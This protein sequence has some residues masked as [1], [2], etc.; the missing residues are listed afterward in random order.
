MSASGIR[1]LRPVAPPPDQL[2]APTR[3]EIFHDVAAPAML[4]WRRRYLQQRRTRFIALG[5]GLAALAVVLVIGALLF[6]LQRSQQ[7]LNQKAQEAQNLSEAILAAPQATGSATGTGDVACYSRTAAAVGTS[8]AAVTC[9]GSPD[10]VFSVSKSS[11]G[12]NDTVVL[13]WRGAQRV[14]DVS[15]APSIGKVSTEGTEV[16]QP[17]E[18]TTY[19]LTA[20][21]CGGDITRNVTVTVTQPTGTVAATVPQPTATVQPTAVPPTSTVQPPTAVAVVATATTET[22]PTVSAPPGVYV[23]SV[24]IDPPEPH[25]GSPIAFYGNFLNTTGSN[26]RYNWC[27]EIFKPDNLRRSE[28]ITTC[29]STEIPQGESEQPSTGWVQNQIGECVLYLAYPIFE[30]DAKARIKFLQ[31]DSQ[32][33]WKDFTLCP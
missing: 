10:I 7:A 21:G 26:Q 24:R 4:D 15:I 1:I 31:P 3:Y 27:V 19:I 17:L 29:T 12:P 25:A 8:A 11:V 2:N 30:D 13:Q 18:T 9:Q 22:S 33:I 14:S 20:T 28:G 16:V 5:L 6:N 32:Q 23:T